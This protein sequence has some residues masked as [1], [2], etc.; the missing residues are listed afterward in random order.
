MKG[1]VLLCLLPCLMAVTAAV[2]A[3]QALPAVV[4]DPFYGEVLFDFYQQNYFSA[5][6]Q[7]SAAQQVGR[8]PNQGVEAE[9]LLGGLYFSYGMQKNA[10][11]IFS[12]LL[13]NQLTP[14]QRNRVWLA[15]ANIH[16][17]SGSHT[18]SAKLLQRLD[19]QLPTGQED[20]RQ[21]LTSILLA[22]RGL[23][24]EAAAQ[25][26]SYRPNSLDS[27]FA[28]YNLALHHIREGRDEQGRPL[29]VALLQQGDSGEP[30]RTELYDKSRIALG[31]SHLRKKE[32]IAAKGWFEQVRLNSPFV[33]QA[34]LGLGWVES[35]M[36]RGKEALAIWLPLIERNVS[37][38]AV[39]EGL[40][41]V[42]YT[43]NQLGARQQA[44][45]HYQTA[46]E[47][48]NEALTTLEGIIAGMN[49]TAL[50][51][52]LVDPRG[53]AE[54]GWHWRTELTPETTLTP[55]LYRVMAGHEFQEALR[56]YRDL[57][58]LETNLSRWRDDLEAYEAMVD[59][60]QTGYE[61]RLPTIL[62]ALAKLEG[63]RLQQQRDAHTQ[64]L[65]GI[66]AQEDAMDLTT[67]EEQQ[68][69]VQLTQVEKRLQQLEGRVEID[70][71]RRKLTVLQG[72]LL[73]QLESEYPARLWRAKQQLQQLDERLAESRGQQQRLNS[74]LE[75]SPGS[76]DH[77]RQTLQARRHQTER[78]QQQ[79]KNLAQAS[80]ARLQHLAQSAVAGV[81]FQVEAYRSQ[82]LFAVAQI[83][84]EAQHIQKE[85]P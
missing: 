6:I 56:N 40:L 71:Q 84:D 66:E 50:A 11:V 61:R 74:V 49:F 3:E 51:H 16:Y 46:I 33:S 80:E 18:E 78:L 77:Y 1:S 73:W 82:A 45:D 19:T 85:H 28:Q 53:A 72:G 30:G 36:G 35:G 60:R 59:T 14:A 42:P 8:L 9:L 47:H 23:Y 54:T 69:W 57:L 34:L 38:P 70:K 21:Q 4:K 22:Q 43:F 13:K 2:K 15:L 65:Q 10:E 76:F 67:A 81:K 26:A 44:L 58:H 41:A 83:Y 63:E 39:L 62:K 27:G 55:Y 25:L 48:Y 64:R 5:I 20:E 7:L 32:F 79:T 24:T 52:E 68:R 75:R 17:K 12:R 29:L 31:Y 37:D